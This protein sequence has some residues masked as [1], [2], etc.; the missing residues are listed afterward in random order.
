MET[1]FKLP[2][3]SSGKTHSNIH[4]VL[5]TVLCVWTV[6]Q[7]LVANTTVGTQE[8]PQPLNCLP[9]FAAGTL[10]ETEAT[11]DLFSEPLG[12]LYKHANSHEVKTDSLSWTKNPS[13]LPVLML[14]LVLSLLW[15]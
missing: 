10:L 12:L 11:K 8:V 7:C 5:C 1:C 2:N 14:A 3:P 13:E 4:S 15:R 6:P 9:F